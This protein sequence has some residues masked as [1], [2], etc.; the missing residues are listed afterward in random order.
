M[1]QAAAVPL[2]ADEGAGAEE[3]VQ[4]LC[5]GQAE[6]AGQ[7]QE[8]VEDQGAGFGL[9]EVPGDVR[10]DRVEAHEAGLV[11]SVGPLVGVD[12]EVVQGA[13][14]DAERFAV[15][16][17]AVCG[18]GEGGH[19]GPFG[20]VGWGGRCGV[21]RCGVRGLLRLGA[22]GG[23]GSWRCG[24]PVACWAYCCPLPQWDVAGTS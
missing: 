7:V 24:E 10:L 6:E 22:V 14:E 16:E 12:A 1:G 11:E 13:G 20:G 15:E 18:R 3:D 9:V 21:G 23:S 19:A 4:A 17:E 2:G 8:A 5:G